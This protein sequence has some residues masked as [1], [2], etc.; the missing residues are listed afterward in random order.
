MGRKN[1]EVAPDRLIEFPVTDA[2]K[3]FSQTDRDFQ[4]A[5]AVASFG[6]LL[7][8][9]PHKGKATFAGVA[10]IAREGAKGDE[11]G[12]RIEFLEL[13]TKAKQLRGE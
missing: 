6:M 7:R 13:V 9:S 3:R 4:F 10:R 12:Y 8:N 2:G 11:S 5:A 1:W